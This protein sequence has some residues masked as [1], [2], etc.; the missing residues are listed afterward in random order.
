L[1]KENVYERANNQYQSRSCRNFPDAAISAADR[2]VGTRVIVGFLRSRADLLE[3]Q[4]YRPV[5]P[6]RM[7]DSSGRPLDLDAKVEAA[8]RE[9]QRRIDAA[10][11]IPIERRQHAVSGLKAPR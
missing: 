9:R 7:H 1:D 8:R 6:T 11:E 2:G 5:L 10:D 4:A 3:N